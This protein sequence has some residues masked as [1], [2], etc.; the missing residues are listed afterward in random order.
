MKRYNFLLAAILFVMTIAAVDKPKNIIVII[1]DG[2]GLN[3]I[4]TL[5]S[6]NNFEKSE[7]IGLSK[8]Y[9][10]NSPVTDS[11]AG[12]TAIAC[13]VKT[14]N[15]MLGLSQDTIPVKSILT[16]LQENQLATGIVVSCKINH[17]TPAAFYAH[18][19]KRTMDSEIVSD[20]YKSNIDLIVG[21]GA[22]LVSVDTLK[23]LGYEICNNIDDLK[24]V[25]KLGKISCLLAKEDMANADQRKDTIPQAVEQALRLLSQNKKGFFLMVEG[26]QID[27]ACHGGN[28]EYLKSE[29]KDINVV[30]GLC[31]DFADANPGTLIIVTADHETGGVSVVGNEKEYHFSTGQHTGVMVPIYSYGTGAEKFSRIQENTEFKNK[32]LDLM[33][34]SK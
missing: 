2:M 22:K 23:S 25:K 15:S 11:A 12:G 31:M 5:D 1:G 32:I 14:N 28:A 16:V 20:L 13:G 33:R 3:Q 19:I 30:L 8:T 4:C 18:Q 26:S 21:G 17:A 7:A 6:P 27:W 10:A 29:I 34:I 24:S 9:S